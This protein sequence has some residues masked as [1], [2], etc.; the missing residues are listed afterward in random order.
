M[1]P[2]SITLRP[3]VLEGDGHR[4]AG[5][6]RAD[7]AHHGRGINAFA[8][9]FVVQAD[10]AAGDGSVEETASFRDPFDGRTSCAMISR[11]FGIAEV[12][13]ISR[14][15]GTRAHRGKI[16]AALCHREFRALARR[17]KAIA[18]VAIERHRDRTCRSP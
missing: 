15:H 6:E 1:P 13:T 2:S 8:Q 9:S 16:A 10:V 3:L 11:P 17:Q 12:Q 18:A 14:G 4:L 7:D 5:F